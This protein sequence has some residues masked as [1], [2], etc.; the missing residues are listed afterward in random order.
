M[1]E[2]YKPASILGPHIT[3]FILEKRS[4]GYDYHSGELVLF[5]FDRYCLDSGLDTVSVDRDFLSGWMEQLATEGLSSQG[6]RIS[7]VRQFLIYMASLGIQVYIPHDFCHFE[8]K[9][10]H[11][12]VREE[13]D[14]LFFEIDAYVPHQSG[15]RNL[16][17]LSNE[18]KVLFRLIYGCGL[19]NSEGAGIA[20]SDV[21]LEAGILS[22]R[23]AKGRKDRLVYLSDDLRELCKEYFQYLCSESGM[24]PK[25]FFPAFDPAHPLKNT[26][27]DKR[28]AAAWAG[29]DFAAS[30]NDKP[31]VHDLRFT[32]VT[33]RIN[34]WIEEGKDIKVMLPYLARFLGHKSISET[35]YYYHLT[36]DA[37]RIIKSRDSIGP[38]AIPE[39]VSYE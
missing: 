9:L 22:I 21:D 18:Y 17:R 5:R 6:K 12:L 19:R 26:T 35:H 33:K 27:V 8:K 7:V 32:F 11:I 36:L 13:L 31:V 23:N 2:S 38:N 28:F 37:A 1:S 16:L 14:A 25:W 10:P 30:C 20:V 4:L 29:T 15:N 3:S 24:V 39:V 34:R